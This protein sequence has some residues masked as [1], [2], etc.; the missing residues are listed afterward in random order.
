MKKRAI[1]YMFFIMTGFS[2]AA[3]LIHVDQDVKMLA[4]GDSYTIGESV[5]MN[6]RWPHQFMEKL[7]LLGLEGMD[8]EYIATTGW[9]TRNLIQGMNSRLV[10]GK[11]YNL[12]SILIGVNNQYQGMNIENYE[13]DLRT[14]IDRALEVLK[15]DT[16]G[17]LILSIPDYA[18]TPF[19]RGNEK[20]SRE[21]DQYNEIKKRV[22]AEY[23][24]AFIDITPI[25][26]EGLNNPSL[27]AGDGLH[28]SAVQYGL[29]VEAIL[30]RLRAE[31]SPLNMDPTGKHEDTLVVYPNPAGSS[32]QIEGIDEI[33]RIR[34]I[35]ITGSVVSDQ[36]ISSSPASLDL[37]R[38]VSGSYTLWIEH[39]KA[40]K[41]SMRTITVQ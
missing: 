25:S 6:Q 29:W 27:V 24:V 9:T 26:R 35:D 41:V 10:E 19:G 33:I 30:P 3:Q 17:L 12:V 37:S 1:I 4:L 39:A 5:E 23:K 36:K 28:P 16:S 8:P 13:P 20:I 7:R 2:A 32:I 11:N 34:V 21:I 38:L 15:Q 18:F 31:G 40:N 14:I 22:A